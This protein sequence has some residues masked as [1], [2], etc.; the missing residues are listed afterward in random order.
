MKSNIYVLTFPIVQRGSTKHA[1][2]IT[3]SYTNLT[4]VSC[5]TKEVF[6]SN[7]I[8]FVKEILLKYLCDCISA[9]RCKNVLQDTASVD[10]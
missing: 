8:S 6:F 5:V 9:N 2:S 7:F 4:H 10:F 1:E 3:C